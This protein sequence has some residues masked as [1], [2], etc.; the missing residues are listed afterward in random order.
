M[1][2]IVN[3]QIKLAGRPV[4]LP[5]SSDWE[6]AEAAVPNLEDG[7]I[8]IHTRFISVDP[9]M[10][11]WMND[12]TTYLPLLQLGEVMRAYMVGQVISSRNPAFT[13]G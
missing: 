3:H 12:I 5:K 11:S 9:A 1:T 2:N 7:Q 10:R 13:E 8:L 6:H 4:G